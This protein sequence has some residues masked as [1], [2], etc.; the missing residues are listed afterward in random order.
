MDLHYASETTSGE[1]TAKLTVVVRD[2][3]TGTEVHTSTL[4]RKGTDKS[5]YAIGYQN[6]S[7][8]SDPLLLKLE[9]YFR[10]VNSTMFE[11]LMT[12][13]NELFTS[14]LNPNSTWMGQYGLRISSGALVD[15]YIPE[16]VFA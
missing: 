12:K 13:V 11:S 9:A 10:T 15:D 14:D 6:I 8:A 5:T 3:T 4:V 16:S 1:A 2:N 7:D